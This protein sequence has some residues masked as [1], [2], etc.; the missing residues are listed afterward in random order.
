MAM[1]MKNKTMTNKSKLIVAT[2]MIAFFAT[3]TSVQNVDALANHATHSMVSN[4]PGGPYPEMWGIKAT[5]KADDT[6]ISSGTLTVPTWV[7]LDTGIHREVGWLDSAAGSFY[8]YW[9]VNGDIENT[10]SGISDGT[11]YNWEVSNINE[12]F[13]WEGS[14]PGLTKSV[15]D[16]SYGDEATVI[17]TGFE[18]S[19]TSISLP[20]I[21]F[22]S[23][24]VY[25]DSAWENW[26]DFDNGR[27]GE[28][29]PADAY[30]LEC[31]N[32]Y[33]TEHGEGAEPGS[34]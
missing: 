1:T 15:T 18:Y 5:Y 30:V 22:S 20:T 7:T 31:G 13:T 33:T 34:C 16:F 17:Q 3:V 23:Q 4:G 8:S 28:T 14:A 29:D 11:T 26:A 25:V 12:D 24:K 21:T 2:V 10:Y 9:A 19:T 6:S 27:I 32:D